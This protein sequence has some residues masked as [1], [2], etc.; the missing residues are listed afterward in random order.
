MEPAELNVPGEGELRGR[1]VSYCGTCDGPLF[2]DKKV[3]AIGGGDTAVEEAIFLAKFAERVTLVHRRDR[4]RATKI[5][6]ERARANPK[7]DFLWDSVVTEITGKTKVEGIKVKNQKTE[8]LSQL[9]CQGVFVFVGS[10]PNTAFLKGTLEMDEKGYIIADGEMKTS[11]EGAFAC[12]DVR[13]KSLRQIVT[14]C[15][16]GAIAAFSAQHYV[17]K[18]KGIEYK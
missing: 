12:G 6:Q 8:K 3:A 11:L 2:K 7:I 9:E 1:G 16:E 14:A 4:L 18:V 17:D 10:N 5:I 13:Q 15:G